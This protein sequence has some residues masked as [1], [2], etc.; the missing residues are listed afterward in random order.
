MKNQVRRRKFFFLN[1]SVHD[2]DYG[3]HTADNF[4]NR[5][6][7]KQDSVQDVFIGRCLGP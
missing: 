1:S 3:V 7:K 2:K 5:I 6:K 4:H